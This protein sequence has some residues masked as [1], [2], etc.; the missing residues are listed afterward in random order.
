MSSLLP[1]TAEIPKVPFLDASLGG[2]PWF[3]LLLLGPLVSDLI[4]KHLDCEFGRNY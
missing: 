1:L 3:R 2:I 4:A